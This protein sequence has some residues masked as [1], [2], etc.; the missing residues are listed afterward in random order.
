MV[1]ILLS[2]TASSA[3]LGLAGAGLSAYILGTGALPFLLCSCAGFI[4]GAVGFYRSTMLQSL[5]MLDRHP[6]LLQL[7]LDANFPGRGFMKWRREELRAER[8][9]G[10]WAMG[11]MLMVALLTAQPAIDR[12]YDDREAV[13]VEEARA[14][15][16]AAAGE[17]LLIEEKGGDGMEA[18]AG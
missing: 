5:A 13:L 18:N 3:C 9:R 2:G 6:R 11:S 15:L 4:F 16:L 14:E 8:F 12:I 7:H 10:S 1:R 17:D